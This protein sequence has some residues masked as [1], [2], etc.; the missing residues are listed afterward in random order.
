MKRLRK[1]AAAMGISTKQARGKSTTTEKSGAKSGKAKKAADDTDDTDEDENDKDEGFIDGDLTQKT[2][3]EE[4]SGGDRSKAI[5]V[6]PALK[7][8]QTIGGRITKLRSSPRKASKANYKLLQDPFST[9]ETSEDVNGDRVFEEGKSS[10]EDTM[11]SDEL[12]N[13]DK[14]NEGTSIKAEI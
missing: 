8:R 13:G 9:L 14:I 12:Y 3:G 5:K 6:E 11:A 1:K 4:V 10:S 2:S 7:Q